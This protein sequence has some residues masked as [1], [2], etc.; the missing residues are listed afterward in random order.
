[1]VRKYLTSG[2]IAGMLIGI[3]G[4]VYLACDSRYAGALLFTTGL[5]SICVLG[6]SLYTGKIGF[7]VAR[8]GREDY[9]E[10]FLCLL[11]NYI[12]ASLTGL[13]VA[14]ATPARRTRAA[15]ICTAKLEIPFLSV[16]FLALFCG[17][18]VYLAVVIY[19]EKQNVLG[20]LFCI[21][22]FILAG[23]EHSIADMFYFAASG[24]LSPRAFLFILVVILGNTAGGMLI[25]ALRLLMSGVRQYV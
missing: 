2:I 6:F 5:L 8:H 4:A 12:G 3:G 14:A 16:F 19:R 20:I 9:A 24:I 1:M 13:A 11:G 7:M 25:P 22:T 23:F 15:E 18:L 21:P 10:L 17:I